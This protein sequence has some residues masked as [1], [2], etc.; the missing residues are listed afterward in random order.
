VPALNK[1]TCQLKA[2]ERIGIAGRTGSGKSTIFSALCRL[3]NYESGQIF[4]DGVD[5]SKIGIQTLRRAIGI[6]PQVLCM[7]VCVYVCVNMCVCCVCVCGSQTSVWILF[8][9]LSFLC[10]SI[11]RI[12]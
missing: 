3:H 1:F 12:C 11:V 5:I 8:N 10:L 2:G 6:V 4:I 7:Y 9:D